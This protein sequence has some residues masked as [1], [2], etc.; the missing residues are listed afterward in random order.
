MVSAGNDITK[1]LKSKPIID[2]MPVVKDISPFEESNKAAHSF[3]CARHGQ[4]AMKAV[5][6]QPV[7]FF[8]QSKHQNETKN[9][10]KIESFYEI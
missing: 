7:P 3:L 4:Y 1:G 2:I 8:T 6:G 10:L 5:R 9:Y